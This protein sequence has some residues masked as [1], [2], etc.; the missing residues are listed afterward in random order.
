M[1]SGQIPLGYSPSICETVQSRASMPTQVD[2]EPEELVFLSPE[3]EF[4]SEQVPVQD[5]GASPVLRRSNCKRKSTASA[6]EMTKGLSTKKKKGSSPEKQ[7]EQA[8]NMPKLPRTP[9]GEQTAAQP[10]GIEALLLAMETRLASK[11]EKTNEAALEATRVAK[12]RSG[13]STW[14]YQFSYDH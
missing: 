8:R 3:E 6:S 11:I 10:A 13:L 7:S 4:A 14:K 12:G 5:H 9:Q 2:E 1:A